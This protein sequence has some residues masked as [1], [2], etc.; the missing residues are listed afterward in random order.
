MIKSITRGQVGGDPEAVVEVSG[1]GSDVETLSKDLRQAF[2][3]LGY[4]EGGG[5]I[6]RAGALV[7]GTL[8]LRSVREWESM[9][10]PE[11]R[12]CGA[13]VFWDMS[14]PGSADWWTVSRDAPAAAQKEQDAPLPEDLQ[15]P[16]GPKTYGVFAV[17]QELGS[18]LGD[19]AK[20]TAVIERPDLL[21]N[22][23]ILEIAGVRLSMEHGERKQLSPAEQDRM[24][25]LVVR[26]NARTQIIYDD[27]A[28]AALETAATLMKNN[29]YAANPS[30]SSEGS[31]AAASAKARGEKY[32]EDLKAASIRRQVDGWTKDDRP[33]DTSATLIQG[34]GYLSYPPDADKIKEGFQKTFAAT[35]SPLGD[36]L[37]ISASDSALKAMLDL[38]L[39][40]WGVARPLGD[41]SPREDLGAS[42]FFLNARVVKDH[43]LGADIWRVEQDRGQEDTPKLVSEGVAAPGTS[44]AEATQQLQ[45]QDDEEAAKFAKDLTF[46]FSQ[47]NIERMISEYETQHGR[48]DQDIR[49]RVS[50][51]L[52]D[53]DP[54]TVEAA[55]AEIKNQDAIK[56]HYQQESDYEDM[57]RLL[58]REPDPELVAVLG[59]TALDGEPTDPRSGPAAMLRADLR[60]L[61]T[62]MREQNAREGVKCRDLSMAISHAEDAYLRLGAMSDPG[63][64]DFKK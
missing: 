13:I 51:E 6:I 32:M 4:Q 16:S 39:L 3:H 53:G 55:L 54:I 56:A 14:S 35:G 7:L 49:E 59:E 22:A 31:A 5:L 57:T 17:L 42:R 37:V 25:E 63:L 58:T 62:E 46:S 8:G 9:A 27:R 30:A 61:I 45:K 44:A 43:M 18:L 28:K 20:A 24:Q 1:F 26:M 47:A 64:L 34:S 2:A 60:L 10:F 11:V 48:L 19:P 52:Y 41:L 40:K 33:R 23:Q 12:Y 29:A 38:N 36:G 15:L 50:A 21:G